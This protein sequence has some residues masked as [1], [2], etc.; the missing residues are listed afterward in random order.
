MTQDARWLRKMAARLE[1]ERWER[2][3]MDRIRLEREFGPEP[4]P[5]PTQ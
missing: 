4:K 5:E 1:A 3:R 2:I